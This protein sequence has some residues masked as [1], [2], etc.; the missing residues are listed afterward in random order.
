MVIRQM[1]SPPRICLSHAFVPSR[2]CLHIYQHYNNCLLHLSQRPKCV[3]LAAWDFL[4]HLGLYPFY[5]GMARTTQKAKVS[6][7][8]PARRRLILRPPKDPK[9]KT[10]A[11][12][13]SSPLSNPPSSPLSNPPSSP[14]IPSDTTLGDPYTNVVSHF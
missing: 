9:T 13:S 10:L 12:V 8:G 3:A 2:I 6:T 1:R 14:P 7:G 4:D 5:T 11:P